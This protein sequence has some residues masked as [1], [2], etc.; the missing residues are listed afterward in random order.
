MINIKLCQFN[1]Y[2]Y[3]NSGIQSFSTNF[4]Q[5]INCWSRTLFMFE[6]MYY[7]KVLKLRTTNYVIKQLSIIKKYNVIKDYIIIILYLARSNINWCC[8]DDWYWFKSLSCSNLF[9]SI[10]IWYKTA[11]KKCYSILLLLLNTIYD[12]SYINKYT[13]IFIM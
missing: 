5:N 11:H 8:V 2:N 6:K 4:F 13:K 10:K 9:K 12:K 7:E 3:L 1:L